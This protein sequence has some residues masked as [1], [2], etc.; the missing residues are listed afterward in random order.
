MNKESC[1]FL[2]GNERLKLQISENYIVRLLQKQFEPEGDQPYFLF[3]REEDN[4]DQQERRNSLTKT[5]KPLVRQS[6]EA[7]AELATAFLDDL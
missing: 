6:A 7:A 1:P 5:S 2:T 3:H 4:R